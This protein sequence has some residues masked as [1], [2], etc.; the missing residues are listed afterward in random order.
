MAT[1]G[2]REQVAHR[3]EEAL[4]EG[5]F[6]VVVV[7]AIRKEGDPYSTD[8]LLRLGEGTSGRDL[9]LL[10]SCGEVIS[11]VLTAQALRGRGHS[12]VALTGAQA[13]VITDGA[14]G[15]ARIL[16]VETARLAEEIESGRI[17]VVAGF[18]GVSEA[19]EVTTTGRGGSDTSAAAIAVALRAERL[20]VFT[21][22]AGVMTADPK[23]VPGAA[24]LERISYREVAELAHQ[25]AKVIHPRAVE[26]AMNGNVPVRVRATLSDGLG[27]T[28]ADFPP[29]AGIESPLVDRPVTG[30]AYVRDL[31]QVS[32]RPPA[33]EDAATRLFAAL[34]EVGVSADMIYVSPERI[35]FVVT[36]G[37]FPRV[38][39][40]VRGL[41]WSYEW[42]RGLAKVSA[43]GAGMH[44]VPGVMARVASA[45][46]RA[47]VPV[48]QTTD[49]HATISVLVSAERLTE[50]VSALHDEFALETIAAPR[51]LA[52]DGL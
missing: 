17:P 13:G 37:S 48:W 12:A 31:A 23:V 16:R 2:L 32:L 11:A 22:V 46:Y 26:I 3:A 27:T 36:E 47:A 14:Y 8:T 39:E 6:P 44:G 21:D 18:Q 5:C 40:V 42:R 29:G 20:D 15:D 4:E 43:V 10:L 9:D 35:V 52:A 50:A 34:K 24:I 45:L 25:G 7:S 33:E 51:R 41:D 30:I 1:E 19:G 38:D 49:S 28:I